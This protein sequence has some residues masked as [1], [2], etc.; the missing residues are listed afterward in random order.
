[1]VLVDIANLFPLPFHQIVRPVRV[2]TNTELSA[3]G[4]P[5]FEQPRRM[6]W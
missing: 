2:L 3:V 6:A 5:F 4:S 1:M